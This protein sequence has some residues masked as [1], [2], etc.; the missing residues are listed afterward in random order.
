MEHVNCAICG[1]DDAAPALKTRDRNWR[2]PG[3]FTLVRCRGCGLVYLDP[4]PSPEE[5]HCYYP[6]AF[7]ARNTAEA[8]TDKQA[9]TSER[10]M[11]RRA[12]PLLKRKQSGKLLDVGCADGLFLV[13]MRKRGWSVYGVEPREVSAR[14]AREKFGLDVFHGYVENA[15]YPPGFFDAI[16]LN[17]VFE[18]VHN[19]PETAGRIRELLAPGG[20][21]LIDVPNFASL[22]SRVFGERWVAVDAPRHLYQFTPKTLL[23]MLE[24]GGLRVLEIVQ[25]SDLGPYKMG[26]SESLRHLI[27]DI[28]LRKYPDKPHTIEQLVEITRTAGR[29]RT[30]AAAFHAVENAFFAAAAGAASAL[31]MGSRIVAIASKD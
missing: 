16:T 25:D 13:F 26:Y 14:T 29:P 6:E 10:V 24:R 27:G 3:E 11:E 15:D 23:A 21:A 18:H 4:R 1:K 12:R 20:V 31:R 28:G 7:S 19:P 22:E 9:D 30:A 2:L 17:H 8:P 5:I